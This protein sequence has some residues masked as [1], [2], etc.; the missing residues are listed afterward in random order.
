MNGPL[1]DLKDKIKSARERPSEDRRQSRAESES[2]N[3]RV[4]LTAGTEFIASIGTGAFVGWLLDNWL[5]TNPWLLIVF[6]LL[7]IA[8]GFMNLYKTTQGIG[9][10]VGFAPLHKSQKQGKQ[11]TDISHS[12]SDKDDP[13]QAGK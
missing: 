4:G 11:G 13:D 1:E 10:A 12:V 3:L 2:N 7:G 6:M 9:S 8:A 5:G